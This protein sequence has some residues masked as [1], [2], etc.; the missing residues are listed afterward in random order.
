[1][2]DPIV[3]VPYVDDWTMGLRDPYMSDFIWSMDDS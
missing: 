1:M 3:L 2:M